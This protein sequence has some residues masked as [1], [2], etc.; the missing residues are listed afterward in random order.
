MEKIVGDDL[1][2]REGVGACVYAVVYIELSV[3]PHRVF[4]DFSRCAPSK[5]FFHGLLTGPEQ[6]NIQ[7]ENEK[8]NADVTAIFECYGTLQQF[9][10]PDMFLSHKGK[11]LH[12]LLPLQLFLNQITPHKYL[13]YAIIL[14]HPATI[15]YIFILFSTRLD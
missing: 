12:Q 10:L 9:S 15:N 2:D 3:L 5:A 6:K 7:K 13:L 1:D 4:S 8:D 11:T 14:I